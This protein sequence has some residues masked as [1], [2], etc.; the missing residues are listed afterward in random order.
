MKL[1][2][3]GRS[4]VVAA[5]CSTGLLLPAAGAAQQPASVSATQRYD[6]SAGP[7][8]TAI[9]AFSRL[10]D[11]TVDYD[12]AALQG[13]VTAGLQGE[14]SVPA[15]LEVLLAGS[16]LQAVAAGEGYAL[17]LV[18]SASALAQVTALPAV[19]VQAE[20]GRP[21]VTEGSGS[22]TTHATSTAT[23][24]DLSLRETPQSA[25][26]VTRQRMDD[27]N[28]TSI[29]DV[30]RY[31]PGLFL[32]NSD[33]PGRP[34]FT[35]RGFYVDNVMYDGLP[36]SYQGWVVGALANLAMYDRVEV[37][38]GAT[39]LVSGSGTPSA[40]INL[41]RKR[42]TADTRLSLSGTA[43]SWDNYRSEVDVSG[44]IDDD[45]NVRGRFVGAYQ[46]A[47]T[48]RDREAYDHGL[49]YAATEMDLSERATLLIGGSYQNDTTNHFWGG[50]PLTET[51]QHMNLPRSTMPSNDW[52]RKDQSIKNVFA[53]LEHRFDNGWK[54]RLAASETW[55]DAVFSGTYLRRMPTTGLNHSAYHAEYDEDQS[56]YDLFATGPFQ[57]LGRQHEL[58]FGASRRENSMKTHAYSGGGLISSNIDLSNWDPG[59]IPEP[60]W[61]Y[62]GTSH[63]ITTQKGAYVASR[64]SLAEPLKLI[65]GGRLD[66]YEY[67]NVTGSGDYKVTGNVTRYAGL[68]Y[69][70]AAQ[71][72][73]YAS[74]TDIF[75]PQTAKDIGG[76]LLDPIVGENYEVGVKGE[77]F[78]G[79]LNAS[80][81]V[82][83]IDQKNRARL[84][85]DQTTCPTYPAVSC[86]EASGLVRSKGVDLEVQGAL[87]RQWQLSAGYTYVNGEYVKD[88]DASNIGKLF[89]SDL[90]KQLFKLSSAYAL[91]GRLDQWRVGGSAY[92]QSG[93]YNDGSYNG[94]DFRV[95]QDTYVLVDVMVGYKATP[96]LDLQLNVNNLLDKT[97]YTA[98]GYDVN[99]G[100]TDTYG[101]PRNFALTAKY[102]F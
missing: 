95:E 17:R 68:I 12:A 63:N 54:L 84:L 73:V 83:Q 90:P 65:L 58:T 35:A 45:G 99:W 24:F 67:D 69:D 100:S 9:S 70:I 16:G 42:P 92:W 98:I 10:G 85:A 3:R 32:S 6:I 62:T 76:N 72:S 30:V 7:L 48:F 25:T 78:D 13:V 31:T 80:I 44:S 34:S 57:L 26:V 94:V 79:A 82:F 56:A 81:A 89:N 8:T 91:G 11:V 43:G 15:A 39:G 46:D 87:T 29:T 60:N 20:A 14:Y 19:K 51:G 37:V 47:N 77:Y 61:V 52:E 27:Q 74:Y 33:G 88:G 59:S 1:T 53:D 50:L 66:W 49:V 28:M 55:Q 5:L 38:R 4:V 101:N 2:S 86:N 102:S 97:Y 18:A 96:K 22:Y 64:F 21:A 41:V 93:I 75:T 71:H 36:S 23:K 40:A